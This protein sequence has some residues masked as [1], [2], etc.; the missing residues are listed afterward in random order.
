[1]EKL[2]GAVKLFR[3]DKGQRHACPHGCGHLWPVVHL[4]PLTLAVG[5]AP[6]SKRTDGLAAFRASIQIEPVARKETDNQ[7]PQAE[8]P[9][10]NF[11]DYGDVR[12]LHLGTKWVQGPMLLDKPSDIELEYVQRRMVWLLFVEPARFL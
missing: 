3:K 2:P 7:L 5:Q 12:Y 9:E 1:M 4:E 8:L 10:V 6:C 11:S